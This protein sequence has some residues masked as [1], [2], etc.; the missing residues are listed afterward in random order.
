MFNKRLISQEALVATIKMKLPEEDRMEISRIDS[1]IRILIDDYVNCTLPEKFLCRTITPIAIR[2]GVG[3][4][5]ETE[6][7]NMI[8]GADHFA[9]AVSE[10]WREEIVGVMK[11]ATDGCTYTVIADCDCGTVD[12]SHD[13]SIVADLA[14]PTLAKGSEYF[15]TRSTYGA[16]KDD[17]GNY[18]HP[19]STN[20]MLMCPTQKAFHGV[21][22]IKGNLGFNCREVIGDKWHYDIHDGVISTNF[23]EGVILVSHFARAKDK[24]G[25]VKVPNIRTYLKA[26]ESNVLSELYFHLYRSK[27]TSFY[28]RAHSKHQIAFERAEEKA[29]DE[30]Y[31]VEPNELYSILLKYKGSWN[32]PYDKLGMVSDQPDFNDIFEKELRHRLM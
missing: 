10:G 9:N 32:R 11:K 5:P 7:V 17:K 18:T 31:D 16:L 1:F 12:C 27:K 8:V 30:I 6:C 23:D 19:Y 15:L 24:K 20:W 4:F 28:E 26:I 14:K 3:V 29:M 22:H 21:K 25:L 13:I 2:R